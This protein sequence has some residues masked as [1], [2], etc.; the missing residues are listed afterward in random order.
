MSITVPSCDYVFKIIVVGDS[1]VGKTSLLNRICDNSVI[2]ENNPTIGVE[3]QCKLQMIDNGEM[4][5]CQMWDTAGQEN[6]A[7]IIKTYYKGSAGAVLCF[8]TTQSDPIKKIEY[9]Y[10]EI[11]KNS[12]NTPQIVVVGTKI[13]EEPKCDLDK[14]S[15]YIQSKNMQLILTSARLGMRH[16]IVLLSLSNKIFDNVINNNNNDDEEPNKMSFSGI[17]CMKLKKNTYRQYCDLNNPNE[18]AVYTKCGKCII[19]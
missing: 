3:F 14:I 5:K 19:S 10:N 2:E 7:P 17:K 12:P 15:E 6:F 13:D 8:D 4:V 11:I 1:G 18:D 9:W 16:E